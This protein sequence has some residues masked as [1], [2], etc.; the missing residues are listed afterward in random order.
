[1]VDPLASAL[2]AAA[3]PYL[4]GA[5]AVFTD[6]SPVLG[7][8]PAP[9]PDE[10]A[11]LAGVSRVVLLTGDPDGV[12]AAALSGAPVLELPAGAGLLAA[13]AVMDRL[14]GPGGCPWDAEQ[15]HSSL[16][17]YLVE[18]TYELLDAIEAGDRAA[19]REE[20][21]D[22]L[23]QV[24][25]HARIAAED[26]KAPFDIDDVACGLA[27][28]L[29][30]RHPHVFARSEHVASAA[31][32]ERRWEELKRDEKQRSS[33]VDGVAFGQPALALAGKLAVRAVRA[34]L[35]V[36]L[37]PDGDATGEVLFA[38]AALAKLAGEDPEGELRAVARRFAAAVRH[39][40]DAARAAGLDPS[41]LDA[42]GWR[43]FFS[44]CPQFQTGVSAV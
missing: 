12:A 25:F 28:K 33:A 19:L 1:V 34:G 10:L 27:S 22:V 4:R 31:A 32:Q 2:P 14:R 36:D 42:A 41:T 17:P 18:E 35:P 37:L 29:I 3:V 16:R 15:T 13:A 11:A 39:A 23:L 44:A 8:E 38:V 21:G 7:V 20:L 5:A 43:R 30:S 24:L 40:E 26:R 6:G 9:P